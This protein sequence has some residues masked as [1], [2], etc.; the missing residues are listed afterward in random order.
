MILLKDGLI[1]PMAGRKAVKGSVLI[2]GNRIKEVG[3]VKEK[4]DEEIDCR[5]KIIMPGLIDTHIHLAQALLRGCADDIPLVRWLN[6]RVWPLQSTYDPE[7]GSL[8]AELCIAEML[9]SGTTTFL[10]SGLHTKYGIDGIARVVERSGIRGYI[11]KMLMD[12]PYYAN[13]RMYEG[14]VED[15]E[16]AMKEALSLFE[17]WNGKGGIRVALAARTHC[18]PE[19]YREISEMAETLDTIAT[20]H[21]CEIEEDVS[22]LRKEYGMSPVEFLEHCG[23]NNERV[24]LA[25]CVWLGDA[26]GLKAN[27]AHCPASNFKLG[28]GIAPV[29]EMLDK[30]VNVTLGCDGA[31]C[32]NTY[33]LFR[34]VWLAS[35]AQKARLLDPQVLNAYDTLAMATINGAKALRIDSGSIAPG[36]LADVITIDL[37]PHLMPVR[38]PASTIVYSAKGSDVCDVIVD[39][40]VIVEDRELKT[41]DVSKL[42]DRVEEK[43]LLPDRLAHFL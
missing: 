36:K 1:V 31:P 11:S 15:K 24:T 29:K 13:H 19:L 23:L 32:N 25:H 6:E 18:T 27:V 10:E 7:L 12:S 33:D 3:E 20:L 2:D 42:M 39:G 17:R 14:M 28:S 26:E 43:G 30:G 8:S 5:H 41:I 37:K 38:D 4:V 40:K 16:E 22:F 34:D 21:F 9:L 35:I